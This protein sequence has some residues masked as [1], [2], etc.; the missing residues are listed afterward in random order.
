LRLYAQSFGQGRDA[1]E[2]FNDFIEYWSVHSMKISM[3]TNK[4][5]STLAVTTHLLKCKM[6]YMN[7]GQRIRQA[8]LRFR[9]KKTQQLADCVGVSRAAVTQWESGDT[10]SLEG[11]NLV[12]AASCLEVRIEWLLTGE[13]PM[14]L[15]KS[16]SPRAQRVAELFDGLDPKSQDTIFEI[17]DALATK[18]EGKGG[19]DKED[20]A[21]TSKSA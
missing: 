10:K 20:P 14:H 9:P 4:M 16:S 13:E 3:L 21:S 19:V 5:S 2:V 7:I 18:R 17:I 15:E 1:A 8:R 11:A 6:T 12:K